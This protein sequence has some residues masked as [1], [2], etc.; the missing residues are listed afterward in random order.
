MSH[1][2]LEKYP[3]IV[4]MKVGPY[5]GYSLNQI[6]D[7]KQKEQK[8]VGKYFWGY[9]GVFCRPNVVKNLVSYAKGNKVYVFFVE[10][11]S[12]FKPSTYDRFNKFSEDGGVWN[13][14]PEDVLLVG[15]KNKAHF[16]IIGNKLKEI[17]MTLDLSQYC[18]LKG[19]FANDNQ[20]FDKYF[21]YRVDKACGVYLP[22]DET[23]K[24]EVQV[25]YVSELVEPYAVYIK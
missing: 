9:S 11:K 19:V 14:L 5:C 4:L 20:R 23:E 7:I 8:K 17:D 13:N 21:R 15:N 24:K 12:D 3:Y 6:I 1:M 10:T 16:A 2:D 25:K 18:T 22:N